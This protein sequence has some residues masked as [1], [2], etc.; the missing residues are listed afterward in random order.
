MK[1]LLWALLFLFL[2]PPSAFSKNL[3][4][5]FE[6]GELSL[7]A[8]TASESDIYFSTGY[9]VG[10]KTEIGLGYSLGYSN[11]CEFDKFNAVDVNIDFHFF[12]KRRYDLYF[13]LGPTICSENYKLYDHFK[14]PAEYLGGSSSL[15]LNIFPIKNLSMGAELKLRLLMGISEYGYDAIIRGGLIFGLKGII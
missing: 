6:K 1:K 7:G 2:L 13:G 8:R 10:N 4:Y 14:I 12:P 5:G 9:A 3:Y 15:G 11:S